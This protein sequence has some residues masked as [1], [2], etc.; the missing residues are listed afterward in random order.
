MS[1]KPASA[2]KTVHKQLSMLIVQI[3][4]TEKPKAW[5]HFITTLCAIVG[6]VF[7]VAGIVDGLLHTGAA[8]VR[9]KV[10]LGKQG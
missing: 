5:Y 2:I 7:V 6:G 8:L 4:V 9:K 1:G 10:D 3:V